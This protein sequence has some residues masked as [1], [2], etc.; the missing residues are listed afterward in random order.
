MHSPQSMS[1]P[2]PWMK[3]QLPA[4][5]HAWVHVEGS[6]TAFPNSFCQPQCLHP[7]FV[8]DDEFKK[9]KKTK[10]KKKIVI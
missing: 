2:A 3:G 8:F 5:H 10:Q 1:F 4:L 7:P 9:K 6:P